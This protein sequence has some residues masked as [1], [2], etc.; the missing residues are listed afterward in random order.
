MNNRR[1]FMHVDNFAAAILAGIKANCA[2]A[3]IVTDSSPLS[4]S[5][6][7][8]RMLAAAG[9]GRRLFPIGR[10]G[11]SLLRKGMGSRGESLFGDAAFCGDRFTA[12]SGVDWLI[13]EESTIENAMAER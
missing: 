11:R 1:S 13:S 2:G 5:E 12:M 9:R 6:L 3:F 4:S 8:A 10:F 7:Y